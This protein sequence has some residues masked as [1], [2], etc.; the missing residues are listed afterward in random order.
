MLFYKSDVVCLKKKKRP[1]TS[2]QSRSSAASDVYKEHIDGWFARGK[3]F[4]L[5]FFAHDG[6]PRKWKIQAILLKE[7]VQSI[8]SKEFWPPQK[9]KENILGTSFFITYLFTV[10]ISISR[11]K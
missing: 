11:M 4:I 5:F 7:K 8:L 10:R 3:H 2:N 1:S 6:T 9:K